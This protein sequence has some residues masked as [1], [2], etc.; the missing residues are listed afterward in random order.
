MIFT[1]KYLLQH[2]KNIMLHL[3]FFRLQVKVTDRLLTNGNNV[4]CCNSIGCHSFRANVKTLQSKRPFPISLSKSPFRYT[5]IKNG[6]QQA[7]KVSPFQKQGGKSKHFL[8]E[9]ENRTQNKTRNKI[10]DEKESDAETINFYLQEILII[11]TKLDSL[12]TDKIS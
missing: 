3:F 5:K 11:G 9:K 1:I 7:G 2:N 8:Q 10:Y 6:R 12:Q 4:S